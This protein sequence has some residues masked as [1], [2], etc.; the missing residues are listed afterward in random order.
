MSDVVKDFFCMKVNT[1]ICRELYRYMDKKRAEC[2]YKYDGQESKRKIAYVGWNELFGM[3]ISASK[4][5]RIVSGKGKNCFTNQQVEKIAETFHIEQEYFKHDNSARLLEVKGLNADIWKIFLNQKYG[6]SYKVE[7]REV[8]AEDALALVKE[9][10]HKVI[11]NYEEDVLLDTTPLYKICWYYENG[12]TYQPKSIQS[13]IRNRVEK[14]YMTTPE[15]WTS[16]SKEEMNE[17]IDMLNE[18][19]EMLRAYQICRDKF[20]IL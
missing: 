2:F 7:N 15:E 9:K 11:E 17:I 4:I 18:T 13:I 14:V 3:L 8:K 20:Q 1:Y 19:E 6:F 12:R 16:C 5:Q 10:L